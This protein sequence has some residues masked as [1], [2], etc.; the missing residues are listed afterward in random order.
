MKNL[1]IGSLLIACVLYFGNIPVARSHDEVRRAVWAGKFYPAEG[2]ELLRTIDQLTHQAQQLTPRLP[3]QLK[4]KALI[5][6]HAGYIYS[7]LTAAHAGHALKHADVRKV[8]LLGPDHHVGFENGAISA[9][10]WWETPLGKVALH[11]D[12]RRLRQG[13]KRFRHVAESDKSEHSLEVLLPFLQVYLTDFKIVPIVIGPCDHRGMAAAIEPVIDAKTLIVV[14]AD[15]S[16]F[17]PYDRATKRDKETIRYIL[18]LNEAPL[19]ADENRSCGKYPIG[20]LLSIARKHQWKPVLLNYTNSGDTAGDRRRV[21]GY[22]AIAFYGERAMASPD[23]FSSGLTQS[24]GHALV[25]LA[26]QTLLA[27][28]NRKIPQEAKVQLEAQLQDDTFQAQ[29]GVFVTLKVGGQLRGCIGSLVGREPLADG[30]RANAL[31]AA[32]NDPRFSPLTEAELDRVSIEVSVLTESQPLAY[33]SATDL[34][35]KLRPK[36]D[37][38]TVRQGFASATFLPQVWEQLSDAKAFL[39]HLC[40]KAGMPGDAWR[41]GDLEVETYQV[42]YFEE[43]H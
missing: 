35:S 19:L 16:H 24:Q 37:G 25:A 20:V 23:E 34:I 27:R 41:Q 21:V 8:I 12:G 40:M 29:C 22:A 18:D 9:A 39:S 11:P 5:L 30:V 6:P 15:L 10:A 14:S 1:T 32:F 43:P 38:V 7:G 28:F 2:G 3:S 42:Q 26:R 17:L 31:N 4:L 13:D 36:I 33:E